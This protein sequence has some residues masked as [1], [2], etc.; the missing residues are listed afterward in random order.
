MIEASE[1]FNKKLTT[2]IR[3]NLRRL[4]TRGWP[5][6]DLALKRVERREFKL[7][8]DGTEGKVVLCFY[9]CESCSQEFKRN[10]VEVDHISPVGSF[11]IEEV[12]LYLKR[13]FCGSDNLQ[14]LCKDECH[15]AKTK[16]DRLKIKRRR[17]L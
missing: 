16:L 11:N 10:E 5:A 7:K 4:A 2:D 17:V 6:K 15:R 1:N 13:L 9:R 8:K 12:T 14:V 3:N